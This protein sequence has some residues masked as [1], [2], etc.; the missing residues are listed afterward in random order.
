MKKDKKYEKIFNEI[1]NNDEF[2]LLTLPEEKVNS[3]CDEDRSVIESF[4]EI[5][6]FYEEN[7]RPPELGDDIGEYILA[8]RLS[9]IKKD[10]AKVKLLLPFDYY[11]LLD[12]CNTKT[13]TIDELITEDPFDLLTIDDDESIYDLTHVKPTDRLRPDYIARRKVCKNFED[14]EE[15]FKQI[16]DDLRSGRRKLIEYKEGDLKEG[17]FYVLRGVA[18]LLEKNESVN[19]SIKYQ[20]GERVRLEGRTRC[21]FDN[22]TESTMLYRSLGKAL[23]LDGFCISDVIDYC[24]EPMSV[25]EDDVQNG[26]IYVL[27]SLSR[28]ANIRSI[29]NLYKIGYCTGDVTDRIKNASNEPTYLMNDVEVVLTVRCYNMNVYYLESCIHSFFEE[30]NINFEVKD[31]KG[32]IHYPKE[33]FTVPLNI[34]EEAIPLIVEKRVQDYVYNSELK[35][36]IKRG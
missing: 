31:D 16:H 34:I 25:N 14:Y 21:I 29:P 13:V 27:R 17:A 18:L 9:A 22:G 35:M 36:I 32:I 10:P 3:Y 7:E 19:K 2:G 33:W 1:L 15:A 6:E 30:V 4:Q 26:F 11:N 23:S 8:A 20:S 24:S 5:S 12:S 28:D